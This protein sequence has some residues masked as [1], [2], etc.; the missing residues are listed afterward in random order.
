MAQPKKIAI[1]EFNFKA[2]ISNNNYYVDKTLLIQ[3]ILEE[4]SRVLLIPRPRRYGKTLNLS[5]LQYFLERTDTDHSGLFKG[6]AIAQ[7]AEAMAHQGQ[8]PVVSLTFKDGKQDTYEE[9]LEYLK[10]IISAE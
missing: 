1:G 6:L 8:Y 7:N 10:G 5:M 2:L 3:E 4:P 9:C